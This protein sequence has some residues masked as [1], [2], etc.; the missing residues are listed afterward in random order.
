MPTIIE[1]NHTSDSQYNLDFLINDAVLQPGKRQNASIAQSLVTFHFKLR[2]ETTTVDA[3]SEV[4]LQVLP[5]AVFQELDEGVARRL[6]GGV[7][8]VLYLRQV[9]QRLGDELHQQ[10]K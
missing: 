9:R 3:T 10:G 5:G 2:S 4:R 7:A 8:V 6:H 1:A